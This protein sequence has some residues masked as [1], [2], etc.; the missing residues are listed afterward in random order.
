LN[1]VHIAICKSPISG[2]FRVAIYFPWKEGEKSPTLCLN[3]SLTF[4]V[5]SMLKEKAGRGRPKGSGIDDTGRIA[6]LK[7]LLQ[8]NPD[9]KP[10]TGIRLMGITDPS[11]IRRIRDKYTLALRGEAAP[12][13][14]N[15]VAG[16]TISAAAHT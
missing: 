12:I 1:N 10:T 5:R 14:S 11:I 13:H 6:R 3:E 7:D 9:L 8:S 16:R 15:Q 4:E 2:L